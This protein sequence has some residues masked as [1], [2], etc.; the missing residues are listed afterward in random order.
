MAKLRRLKASM[1]MMGI[2]GKQLAEMLG[3]GE[4]YVSGILNGKVNPQ[5]TVVYQICDILEISR[6]DIAQYFPIG[7]V[8][9]NVPVSRAN[10]T[11]HQE[12]R[13]GR[14]MGER[15]M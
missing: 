1:D 14:P 8:K 15:R 10:E 5:L 7:E 9:Y 6:C 12:R 11:A 3:K 4:N 13:A 2:N